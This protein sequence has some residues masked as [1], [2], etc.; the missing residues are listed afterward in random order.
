LAKKEN[1]HIIDHQVINLEIEGIEDP[2]EINQIQQDILY[3]YKKRLGIELEKLLNKISSPGVDIQI[4]HI[5]I[6]L[7]DISFSTPAELEKQ[8]IEKFKKAAEK[9]IKA[10]IKKIQKTV[11]ESKGTKK[12]FSKAAILIFF[13]K[14]GYYPSWAGSKNGTVSEIFEELIKKRPKDFT[15]RI[16]RMGKNKNVQERLYQ[17]FSVDQLELLFEA[18]YGSKAVTAYKQMRIIQKRLGAKS[19]KAIVSAAINYI[20]EKGALAKEGYTDKAF[21]RNVIEEVQKRKIPTDNKTKVRAGFEGK[22]KDIQILEYFLEHGAIPSWGDVDSDKSFQELFKKMLEQEL[23]NLQRMVERHAKDSRFTQRLIFQFSTKDILQLLEPTSG[24]NLRFIED[25]LSD[26]E[27]LSTSRQNITKKISKTQIRTAVLT[28]ALDYFFLYKKTKFVKKSFVIS[29]IEELSHLSQT[30]YDEVVKESY[31]SVRRKKTKTALQ[32]ILDL[33]D[34]NLKQKIADER[35]ELRESKKEYREIQRTLD[36]LKSKQ[37]KGTLSSTDLSQLKKTSK[38]FNDLEQKIEELGDDDMPL[39]IELLV[40]QQQ[41]LKSQLKVTKDKE[42][43]KIEKRLEN[44]EKEFLKLQG[45]LT[46]EIQNLIKDKANL[47]NQAGTITEKRIKRVN[48]R[49]GKHHRAV[50]NIAIQLKLDQQ[51]VT[52]FLGNI[53]KALRERI[54]PEEK[55]SLRK[56]RERLQKELIK[57]KEYLEQLLEEEVKLEGALKSAMAAVDGEED[58][59]GVSNTSK[60]DA[61]IFMLK[62]GAS[63][64]W[65][66]K[67]PK[68]S[69]EELFIEFATS[70]PQK[71]LA[72]FQNIGKYPVV[73][74]RVVNQLSEKAIKVVVSKLYPTSAT[75]VIFAEADLLFTLHY[76][77]GFKNLKSVELKKFQWS[78]ILEYILGKTQTFNPQ[79]FY[80]EVTLE[81]ARVNNLSPSKFI[82]YSNNIIQN[83]GGSLDSFMPW[84]KAL[85]KDKRVSD[86]DKEVFAFRRQQEQKKQGLY[87]SDAQK[88]ELVIGFLSTGKISD[89]AKKL[90]YDNFDALQN[91][92]LEQIQRNRVN[93]KDVVTKLL[94]LSNARALIV[95]E[96]SEDTFW[97]IVHLVRP[98]ALLPIKRHFIDFKR[99]LKDKKLYQEKDVLLNFLLSQQQGTFELSGYLMALINTARQRTGR[100]PIALIL[101]W[102]RRL[103]QLGNTTKSSWFLSV[104]MLEVEFLKEEQKKSTDVQNRKILQQQLESLAE[105]YTTASV[106]MMAVLSEETAEAQGIPS[107]DY[108]LRE[109]DLL[110]E[111]LSVELEK[112]K[113]NLPKA[114]ALKGIEDKRKI[115][116]IEAQL[117]ILKQRR[118]PLVRKLEL[119]IKLLKEDLIELDRALKKEVDKAEKLEVLAKEEAFLLS[120]MERQNE[121]LA[122]VEVESEKAIKALPQLL[123]DLSDTNESHYL[124]FKELEKVAQELKTIRYKTN[125]LEILNKAMPSVVSLDDLKASVGLDEKQQDLLQ[126]V[127]KTSPF[128]LWKEWEVL[129]IYYKENPAI[130]TEERATLQQQIY[131]QI[132]RRD[133]KNLLAYTSTLQKAQEV[134]EKE[135]DD[136]SSKEVLDKLQERLVKLWTQQQSQVD[137]MLSLAREEKSSKDFTQLR[138]NIDHVF[139]KLENKR[140]RYS[141]AILN[142][143]KERL[144]DKKVEQKI[145]VEELEQKV[146]FIVD[147]IKRVE[148]PQ[149]VEEVTTREKK[150]KPPKPKV[151]EEPLQVFNAGLVLLWPYFSRLFSVLKYTK[152]KEFV[153]VEM[154]YKA[155]HILQYLATGK[156]QAPENELVLNKIFCNFP[157]AEPVP[158]GVEFDPNELKT[159]EGLLQGAIN[160]WPKMKTMVPN[161]LRGSFLIREGMIEEAEDRWDLTVTK[162]PYDVL[163]SSIPWGYTF[164]KLPWLTKVVS[165]EWKLF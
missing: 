116:K 105:E 139:T 86:L 128:Q 161:S 159:A 51:D 23:V 9:Q 152:G 29:V 36:K 61:L 107:K 16:F 59:V 14:N 141:Y 31:K 123:A 48:S 113:E 140:K 35:T 104:L 5:E 121:M 53:N 87:L 47:K 24:D 74:E 98:Q 143:E 90:K 94:R 45:V 32:P 30:S 84:N 55:S 67:F 75:K 148:E 11:E 132:S 71:L 78:N 54:T 17:Q 115:V 27:F 26:F 164:I 77:Q 83:K 106:E 80:R 117:K 52:L 130:Y 129:E 137:E 3:F 18:L 92:L 134:L 154:Q 112:I 101:D 124:Y 7:E 153:S 131:K 1:H 122:L 133:K 70:S 34:G 22:Y 6:D 12:K 91:L 93:T 88:L 158:F 63:P 66:E 38:R 19:E 110:V 135:L 102:K 119:K 144:E 109:I 65:A 62:Y 20:L 82:E 41:E 100:Q 111:T 146:E 69:I 85:A 79:H 25:S 72:A 108:K 155:I 145:E 103:M 28:E 49:L 8:M 64:W 73:W 136:A 149:K 89:A 95:K 46:K 15:T 114:N 50:K 142:K 4:D 68:Q 10:K 96:L 81:T 21:S 42:F 56:E 37:E 138:K 60:L 127:D 156:T 150:R 157:I 44:S 147:E 126:K 125:I 40:K 58:S 57:I 162:K 151:I 39:E 165:V 160:N 118:P 43:Q 2:A 33:L 163:L 97:E 99:A 120:L 76:S 13:L